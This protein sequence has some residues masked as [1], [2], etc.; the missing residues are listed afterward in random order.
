MLGDYSHASDLV[1]VGYMESL[2]AAVIFNVPDIDHS[3]CVA[4]DETL[5]ASWAVD[6]NQR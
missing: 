6:S 4:C 2:H 1:N 5:K 3:F